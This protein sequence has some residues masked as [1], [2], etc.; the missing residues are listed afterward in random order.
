MSQHFSKFSLNTWSGTPF[1]QAQLPKNYP[2]SRVLQSSRAFRRLPPNLRRLAELSKE[3]AELHDFPGGGVEEWY[4][5]AGYE[6][7]PDTGRRLTDAE[8]DREWDTLGI[9]ASRSVPDVPAPYLHPENWTPVAN[10]DPRELP[11]PDQLL[12]DIASRGRK[13]TAEYWNVSPDQLPGY[14]PDTV[15]EREG[16]DWQAATERFQRRASRVMSSPWMR[17]N[18]TDRKLVSEALRYADLKWDL[19]GDAEAAFDLAEDHV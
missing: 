13:A 11:T 7:D 19:A 10:A 14:S 12:A 17:D 15:P 18:P 5:D 6:L 8:V 4:D 16:E 9:L 3:W 2:L 1:F